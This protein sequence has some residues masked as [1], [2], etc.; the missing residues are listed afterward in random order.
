MLTACNALVVWLALPHSELSVCTLYC[1]LIT[2]IY[3][4][5]FTLVVEYLF[6][7]KEQ[8]IKFSVIFVAMYFYCSTLIKTAPGYSSL[9]HSIHLHQQHN[10]LLLFLRFL[11]VHLWLLLLLHLHLRQGQLVYFKH[12]LSDINR[13]YQLQSR[14]LSMCLCVSQ[15][16]QPWYTSRAVQIVWGCKML[17]FVAPS[18]Q[19]SLW[20]LLGLLTVLAVISPVISHHTSMDPAAEK[21]L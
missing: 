12:W 15:P 2:Q 4:N 13:S 19:E 1:R 16:S 18:Y 10:L 20:C 17:R 11:S 6:D 3:F 9:F 5:P 8:Y 7:N 21:G 14:L